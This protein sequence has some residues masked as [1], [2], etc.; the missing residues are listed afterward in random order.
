MPAFYLFPFWL[1]SKKKKKK[2]NIGS[3]KIRAKVKIGRERE[4]VRNLQ[5]PQAS[6]SGIIMESHCCFT[7]FTMFSNQHRKTCSLDP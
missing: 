3:R 7:T 2:H 6:E 4:C 1:A 5:L